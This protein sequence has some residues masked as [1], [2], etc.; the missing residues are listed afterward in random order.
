MKHYI[1]SYYESWQAEF[2][3]DPEKAAPNCKASLDFYGDPITREDDSPEELISA[4][5]RFWGPTMMELAS[6]T[7]A[8]LACLTK[9][10]KSS[11]AKRASSL[12]TAP[13]ASP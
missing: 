3:I 13:A 6:A 11:P 8:S 4:F 9:W 5:F 2:E 10:W 7:A 1:L 12:W